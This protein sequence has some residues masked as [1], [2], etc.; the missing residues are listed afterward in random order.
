MYVALVQGLAP[1][2]LDWDSTAHPAGAGPACPQEDVLCQW[3]GFPSSTHHQ[4]HLLHPE[5]TGGPTSLTPEWP[6]HD[7][8][9]ASE[10]REDAPLLSVCQV[11]ETRGHP[12]TAGRWEAAQWAHVPSLTETRTGR[13]AAAATGGSGVN[14]EVRRGRR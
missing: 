11:L 2:T 1:V 4:L 3:E 14:V 12:L 6:G 13:Q 7:R 9:P 8:E 5:A 10:K